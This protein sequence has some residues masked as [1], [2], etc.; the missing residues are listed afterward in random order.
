MSAVPHPK[1]VI[2]FT[3]TLN[4]FIFTII[5]ALEIFYDLKKKKKKLKQ[6]DV[7]RSQT[8]H[9]SDEHF[10]YRNHSAHI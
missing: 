1:E 5:F 8:V 4:T 10:F 9:T 2:L 7:D 6:I 3:N